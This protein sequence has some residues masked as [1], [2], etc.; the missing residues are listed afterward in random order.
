MLE[1]DENDFRNCGP[2]CRPRALPPAQWRHTLGP[3]C[4]VPER[5]YW[6]CSR[7]CWPYITPRSKWRHTLEWG[8]CA[9]AVA[10]PAGPATVHVQQVRFTKDGPAIS[11]TPV[12][13]E[14]FAP[15]VAHLPPADQ[16]EMLE[17][18]ADASPDLRAGVVA[19]WWRTA[20]QLADSARREVLLGEYLPQD[21]VEADRPGGA[22]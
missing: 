18:V 12:L 16:R 10:R 15:W 13:L 5:D 20:E 17:D 21:F 8:S 9:K 3:A 6:G 1:P 4:E 19:E 11:W 2:A 7:D 14:V 22:R